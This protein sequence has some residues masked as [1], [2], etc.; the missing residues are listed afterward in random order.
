MVTSGLSRIGWGVG[1]E[2]RRSSG[3]DDERENGEARTVDWGG[4]IFVGEE[5]KRVL[6]IAGAELMKGRKS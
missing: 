5:G 3:E 4:G 2:G 1:E 6:R